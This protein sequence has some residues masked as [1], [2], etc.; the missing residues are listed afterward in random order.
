VESWEQGLRAPKLPQIPVI[1]DLLGCA[2]D[3]LLRDEPPPKSPPHP[4]RGRK[5]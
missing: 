1:A 5:G 3:D 4:G 2:I